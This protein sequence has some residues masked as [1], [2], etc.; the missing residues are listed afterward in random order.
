MSTA[1]RRRSRRAALARGAGGAVRRAGAAAGALPPVWRGRLLAAMA[2]LA[3]AAFAYFGWFRDSSFAQIEEVTVDGVDGPQAAAIRG[4]LTD[5]AKNMTTLHVREDELREAVEAYPTVT[6]I[7]ADADFPHDLYIRVR[8]APP[9]GAIAAG[10]ERIPVGPDGSLLKGVRYDHHLPLIGAPAP[11]GVD[12]LETGEAHRLLTVLAAAPA[13]MLRRVRDVRVRKARGIVVRLRRGPDLIFG[14]ATRLRAKW[15]AATRVLA[16]RSAQGATYIDLRLPERPAAGGL[17][18]ESV[19]PTAV[20]GL[21]A[22]PPDPAATTPEPAPQQSVPD[23]A[24]TQTQPATT[25]PAAQTAP[26]S[27]APGTQP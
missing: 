1:V 5:A 20:P 22:A 18:V 26:V 25:P 19:S 9:V 15:V 23:P 10:D 16:S 7:E 24:T 13:R 2:I 6:G 21:E 8:Q 4:A 27:P 11:A 3:L 12:R 14:D 17:A